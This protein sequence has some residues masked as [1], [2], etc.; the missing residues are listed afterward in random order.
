MGGGIAR[1]GEKSEMELEEEDGGGE[2]GGE[3][4]G[5]FAKVTILGF[6]SSKPTFFSGNLTVRE[7]KL[8]L[9]V[10]EDGVSLF[11]SET[12]AFIAQWSPLDD[13]D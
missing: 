7:I 13:S 4:G 8:L 3:G 10:V 5:A 2:E 6:N 1:G 9:Q 11:D 12:L